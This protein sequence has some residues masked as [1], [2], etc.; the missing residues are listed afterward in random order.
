M[1]IYGTQ[2][3]CGL[4]KHYNNAKQDKRRNR[5]ISRDILQRSSSGM[6]FEQAVENSNASLISF[7]L[8][9]IFIALSLKIPI[10]DAYHESSNKQWVS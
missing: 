4:K 9:S 6:A 10:N 7:H 2:E 8:Q 3:M 5:T 1:A